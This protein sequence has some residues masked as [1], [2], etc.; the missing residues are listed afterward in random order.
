MVNDLIDA[1]SS[2]W[3]VGLVNN[4]FDDE[5][6]RII[7]GMPTSVTGGTDQLIWHYFRHGQYTVRT[8]YGVAIELHENGELGRKGTGMSGNGRGED[9]L[10]ST[11]FRG[12]DF[13]DCWKKLFE[14]YKDEEQSEE[15]FQEMA[16][17]LW[18]IW[19]CRNDFV[20]NGIMRDPQKAL[21]LL[22]KHLQE[23]KDV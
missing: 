20:F 18:R 23:Y 4:L 2:T 17:V 16:F 6:A 1:E 12:S 21:M 9:Q 19:K 14:R 13:R 7:L 10:D 5:E 3:D 8:G 15:L 22:R 11:G